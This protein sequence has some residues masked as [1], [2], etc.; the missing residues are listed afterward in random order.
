MALHF[1]I[2]YSDDFDSDLQDVYDYIADTLHNPD[3]AS[4]R[5]ADIIL[6]AESLAVSPK[7]HRIRAQ[8]SE[9]IDIRVFTVKKHVILYSVDDEQC[10][11]NISRVFYGKRDID[12]LI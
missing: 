7:R 4:K 12:A 10:I 11:V 6:A 1:S 2:V 3:A 8:N 9:G 5:V